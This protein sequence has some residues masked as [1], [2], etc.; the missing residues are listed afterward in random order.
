MKIFDKE[1]LDFLSTSP[2]NYIFKNTANKSEFGKF[3]SMFHLFASLIIL[4]F[5]LYSYI[6]GKEFNVIYSKKKSISKK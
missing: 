1:N 6:I 3:S 5:Y 4:I 2:G